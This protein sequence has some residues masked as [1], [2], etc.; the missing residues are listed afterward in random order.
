MGNKKHPVGS[1]RNTTQLPARGSSPQPASPR[2]ERSASEPP[3][4][5]TQR[6]FSGQNVPRAGATIPEGGPAPV[7]PPSQHQQPAQ[8]QPGSTL[9][10]PDASSDPQ[11]NLGLST[12][13]SAPSVPSS[14]PKPSQPGAAPVPPPRRPTPTKGHYQQHPNDQEQEED[15][16]Q[17][18][19]RHIP[20]FVEGRKDP[21]YSSRVNRGDVDPQQQASGKKPSDFYPPGVTKVKPPQRHQTAQPPQAQ[22]ARPSDLNVS[23]KLDPNAEPTSPLSPPTGPIAM[24]CSASHLEPTSPMPVKEG[25]V[26][27]LPCSP[28]FYNLE[29][30]KEEEKEAAAQREPSMQPNEAEEENPSRKASK[31]ETTDGKA[32]KK[33]T[34]EDLVEAQIEKVKAAVAELSERIANFKGDKKDKEY[35]YLDEMLTRHLLSLDSVET[36]GNEKLRTLRKESIRSINRCLSML[37]NKT[38]QPQQNGD[39]EEN[40]VVLEKLVEASKQMDVAAGEK[41]KK[42]DSMEVSDK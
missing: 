35:L 41:A 2:L 31:E 16:T 13:A 8:R 20:I 29:K 18:Q 28:D 11:N 17:H 22:H 38:Q 4:A 15:L 27:A 12:S 19:I 10:V 1:P 9:Q 40:N 25:E 6:L 24:G 3:K 32:E 33:P 37:D 30:N 42:V 39:A 36:H 5:F 23:K 34:Q 7:P 21:V 26:I 14:T